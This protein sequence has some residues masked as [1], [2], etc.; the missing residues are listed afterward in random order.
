MA[1]TLGLMNR[2][3]LCGR[4][5]DLIAYKESIQRQMDD[6]VA[7][8]VVREERVAGLVLMAQEAA[9]NLLVEASL[10]KTME[11]KSLVMNS[12]MKCLEEA[13]KQVDRLTAMSKPASGRIIESAQDGQI[14]HS[15]KKLPK[16][17]RS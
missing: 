17:K 4:S 13:G 10:A 11:A 12:A 6:L 1:R 15:R 16:K 14:T 2:G 5:I 7:N 9:Q 3:K 8:G